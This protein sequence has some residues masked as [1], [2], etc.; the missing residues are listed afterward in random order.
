MAAKNIIA[1]ILVTPAAQSLAANFTG[2]PTMIKFMDNIAYQINITTSNSTGSFFVD[3][4]LDYEQ[5]NMNQVT[6]TGNWVQL[7]LSGTPAANGTNDNIIISLN[8]LPFNAVRLRYV[9]TAAG[10]G[11]CAAYIMSKQI[12]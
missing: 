4:S 8:Q 1:P 11:T 3:A 7:T 10:T 9:S 12:A 2:T 6:Q 5:I